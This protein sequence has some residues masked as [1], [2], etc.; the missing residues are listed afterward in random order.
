MLAVGTLELGFCLLLSR[1]RKRS[2]EGEVDGG[3]E[4]LTIPGLGVVFS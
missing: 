3:K 1:R 2:G 4:M